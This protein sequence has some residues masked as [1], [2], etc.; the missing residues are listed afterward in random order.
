MSSVLS[1]SRR[2]VFLGLVGLA[3]GWL[4]AQSAYAPQEAEYSLTR[5]LA[6]DQVRARLAVGPSGGYVVWE[7][8]NTD[9]DGLGVSARALNTYLSPVAPKTFRV[10][11]TA[12]GD[13]QKPAAA[14][15]PSGGAVFVWQGGPQGNQDIFARFVG[16]G[17]TFATGEVQVN[18]TTAADQITPAA[19]VLADGSV[20]VVWSSFGQ[21][22][23]MLGVF[24]QRLSQTGERLGGEFRVNQFT[25]FNQRDPALLTLA[26]GD[27]VVAWVSEQQRFELSVDVFARRY[28]AAGVALGGEFL[29]N[30]ST[31]NCANPT[32]ATDADGGFL[33][34]WSERDLGQIAHGWDVVLRAFDATAAP[35]TGAVRVNVTQPGHQ[36][37]PQLASIGSDHL[38]VWTSERQDGS[39]E[40]VYGR[41]LKL[42]GEPVG[43]EFRVNTTTV[44]RQWFPAV[45]SDGSKRFIACWSSFVGGE[46]S[47]ELMAQRY[48]S[49]ESLTQPAPPYV[50]AL[51]QYSLQVSW[52][53]LAG[54]SNVT[55]RV[56]LDD[57]A[58]PRTTA[59]NRL[60]V[61]DLVPASTHSLQMAYDVG[62][63]VSPKSEPVLATTW[64][65]DLTGRKLRPDGVP[66]DWQ[67]GYWGADPRLWPF[68]EEDSDGDGASNVEEF[69]AG[70]DP[71][72][73]DSVLKARI[74]EGGAGLRLAWNSQPGV[75]YQVQVSADL[76]GWQ[77]VGNHAFAA[78][79]VTS[80]PISQGSSATYYRVIRI[81]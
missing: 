14:L 34:A 74:V 27:V 63:R 51:D 8:N 39:R 7:D 56:Y 46:A 11:E 69:L 21:D 65:K 44:S 1:A 59:Q 67:T 41:V 55:Y 47:V 64:G 17:G 37:G 62:G 6:G 22:G 54:A 42:K 13:Q 28:S 66:D 38:V 79:V 52:P 2:L 73:A 45:G 72:R 30:T 16:P 31:N 81:R 24:A 50:V 36:F 32:L 19:T 49:D 18:T 35:L 3:P 23:D 78:G 76:S 20:L 43:G 29:V 57:A 40:G 60:V 71:T 4:A 70:T 12:A 53:E 25:G 68:A 61:G 58:Q 5:G 77:D 75:L 15:L 26:N 9:G 80:V 48:S 33:L 10:N